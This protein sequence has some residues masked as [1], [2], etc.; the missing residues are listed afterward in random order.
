MPL[1][2]LVWLCHCLWG[3]VLDVQFHQN[4]LSGLGDAGVV[5]AVSHC[6]YTAAEQ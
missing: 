4:R 6:S 5:L 2:P 3:I 1:A